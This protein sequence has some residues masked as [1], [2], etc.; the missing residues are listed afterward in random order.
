MFNLAFIAKKASRF[1]YYDQNK[2]SI[3]THFLEDFIPALHL[4][5]KVN[6]VMG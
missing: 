1:R 4:A 3:L 2:R 5:R 6:S